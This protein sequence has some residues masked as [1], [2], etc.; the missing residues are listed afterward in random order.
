VEQLEGEAVGKSEYKGYF[1]QVAETAKREKIRGFSISN[2]IPPGVGTI[3]S[4]DFGYSLGAKLDDKVKPIDK[5]SDNSIRFRYIGLAAQITTQKRLTQH[6]S[7]AQ[8]K[9]GRKFYSFLG[10]A[11]KQSKIKSNQL[12]FAFP[13]SPATSEEVVRVVHFVSIFD[14]A[15]VENY[16]IQHDPDFG[17]LSSGDETFNSV[18]QKGYGK[19]SKIGLNTSGD[20]GEGDPLTGGGSKKDEDFIIGA[21]IYLTEDDPEVLAARTA[22]NLPNADDILTNNDID[23]KQSIISLFD[24]FSQRGKSLPDTKS[25][26]FIKS[27]NSFVG[28]ISRNDLAV[29]GFKVDENRDVKFSSK[30]PDSLNIKL[31]FEFLIRSKKIKAQGLKTLFIKRA[32]NNW[33]KDN[34]NMTVAQIFE[35]AQKDYDEAIG[36]QATAQRV[37]EKYTDRLTNAYK[38]E[39]KPILDK[40]Y[41]EIEKG[42]GIAFEVLL[43]NALTDAIGRKPTTQ[44]MD[45]V[46]S[47]NTLAYGQAQKKKDIYYISKEDLEKMFLILQ[48][49]IVQYLKLNGELPGSGDIA[50]VLGYFKTERG[51]V[52]ITSQFT[53]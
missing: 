1:L 43:L 8:K 17:N 34:L 48:E 24:I 6:V 13:A 2:I 53:K 26:S 23:Y 46:L 32:F 3:Y 4:W 39:I 10:E 37:S 29:R 41:R 15:S 50:N 25:S 28:Q 12:S 5:S 7:T 14:L 40:I 38:K 52:V 18:I 19:N 44:E 20:A 47:V 27:L 16:M 35:E 22:N 11:I 49:Y 31:T 51:G 33:D 42:E 9:G 45:D 36:R 30:F 21:Y